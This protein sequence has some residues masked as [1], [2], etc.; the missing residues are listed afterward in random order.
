MILVCKFSRL[1]RRREIAVAFKSQL[2]R[3]GIRLA[4][5]VAAEGQQKDSETSVW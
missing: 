4:S 5:A 1:T 2:R 3:M